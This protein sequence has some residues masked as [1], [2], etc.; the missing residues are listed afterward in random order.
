MLV[1]G[2]VVVFFRDVILDAIATR[3]T[4]LTPFSVSASLV[5]PVFPPKFVVESFGRCLKFD[6]H[7]I[8]PKS[9][10]IWASIPRHPPLPPPH[11]YGSV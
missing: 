1:S 6:K 10:Y 11:G 4:I 7:H 5:G 2:S 3:V 9:V 8:F